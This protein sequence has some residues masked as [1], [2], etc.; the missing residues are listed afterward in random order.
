MFKKIRSYLNIDSF[1]ALSIILAL[2]F[3]FVFRLTD[4]A[5]TMRNILFALTAVGTI[6][7]L[8]EMVRSI[9]RKQF[10]V[11]LIAATAIISALSVGEVV[12]AAVIL[13]MLSGGKFLETFAQGKARRS[14]ENLL[15][16]TPSVAHICK[17]E[18]IVDTD[19]LK[20]V[21][22]DIVLVKQGEIIPIDG[23]VFNSSSSIDES[24][25]TGEPIPRDVSPND[26]VWSGTLNQENVIRVK[27]VSIYEQSTFSGI[28]R[29]IKKAEEE[30]APTVRLADK[31]SV[32]FTVV[33]FSLA[34][35]AFMIN[36]KLA[37]AVLVVATPCPLILAAPIA[38]I[39]G[40][41]R[42]AKKGIIVKHGGVFEQILKSKI[43]L[44]DKTGTL[45]FGIPSVK[46]IISFTP[47]YSP[48]DIL[49]LSASIEQFSTHILARSLV[50]K[51]KEDEIKLVSADNVKEILGGG[52]V[53]SI[54]GKIIHLGKDVFF[55]NLGIE[56]SEENKK[57]ANV[58]RKQEAFSYISENGKIIGVIKFTDKIRTNS[59][60]VLEKI[61]KE[62]K[63]SE[64]I[65][66]TGDTKE[67]AEEIAN[68]LGFSKVESECLPEN[69]VELVNFYRK[70][71]NGVVMIGDG[72][73]D[74]PALTAASVGIA[75]GSHGATASTDS[76]DA[77]IAVDDIGKVIDLI[78][79]SERTMTVAKQ[80]IFIGMG[81]STLAM[82]F[83]FFGL[84]PP[85]EGA[86]LQ[87]GIDVLV[88]LNA[89]RALK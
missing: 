17:G 53:G 62:I 65:L 50:R 8:Y 11:D 2:F 34:I 89:L 58:A 27:T 54:E 15:K 26:E 29:L 88:I 85:V 79:T 13:L 49:K 42:S 5:E 16:K 30:K 36:P 81:L 1:I 44:F 82:I 64:T 25:I 80:S 71:G 3:V 39:S 48:L 19:V 78:K 9:I 52:I 77:V 45:T 21:V 66:V 84:I 74:A 18:E 47:D 43:F 32:V 6:P 57:I 41:S 56:R 10:G 72:V 60:E 59:K 22:G 67:R 37:T 87:E 31:Y 12:A 35:A 51:A 83:A 73:N 4:N 75:L 14:L 7:L 24:A 20:I 40:M 86:I 68:A 70:E 28:I 69:K 33:T 38:F 55:E 61:R 46:E 23:I 76:A 63:D